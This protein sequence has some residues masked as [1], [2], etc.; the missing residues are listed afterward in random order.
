MI[1]LSLQYLETGKYR[2][3]LTGFSVN[4]NKDKDKDK[5]EFKTKKLRK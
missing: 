1:N 4:K 5:K 3:K 2:S